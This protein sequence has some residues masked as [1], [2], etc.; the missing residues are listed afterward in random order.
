MNRHDDFGMMDE[1]GP[2]I[3]EDDAPPADVEKAAVISDDGLYRYSLVRRWDVTL[4][5]MVFI[6]LNPSTADANLDDPTIR[7]CMG[8]A[9]TMGFGGIMVVNLFA[10]RATSP[11]D[12]KAAEDPVGLDN[13]HWLGKAFDYC[14]R[15]QRSAVAAWGVHGQ[16]KD[17]DYAVAALAAKH[18]VE[19]MCLGKTKGGDPR[20][21][22]YVKGDTALEPLRS[23]AA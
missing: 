13:D 10:F 14:S 3:T 18:G 21:P 6:M 16:H 11:D 1:D 2:V 5:V 12:M 15:A 22:L 8:F 4:P 17:R 7:R 19:L 23:Q 20:H 9:R